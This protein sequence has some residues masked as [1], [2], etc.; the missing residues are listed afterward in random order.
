MVD[1]PVV[2]AAIRVEVVVE[3]IRRSGLSIQRHGSFA[4]SCNSVY[5][6]GLYRPAMAFSCVCKQFMVATRKMVNSLVAGQSM[7]LSSPHRLRV[8]PVLS[9]QYCSEAHDK[10][11]TS[12]IRLVF[13][14]D[15]D[16]TVATGS[17]SF[18]VVF[19]L[20]RLLM[21]GKSSD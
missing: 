3:E 13:L 5:C 8:D 17:H 15:G 10:I 1:T 4:S 7:T 2:A 19:L 14:L 21:F 6:R 9:I 20:L 16:G 18:V 12:S 11:P